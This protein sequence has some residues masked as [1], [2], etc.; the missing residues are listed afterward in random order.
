MA[1]RYLSGI[2]VDSNTLFVDSANDRVGIGTASPTFKLEVNGGLGAGVI[3][4]TSDSIEQIVVRLSSDNNKQLILGRTSTAAR[5]FGVTQNVGYVPLL[6]NE[7]GGN[8]L[9]GTTTDAGYKLDVSGTGRFT[10]VLSTNSVLLAG[11]AANIDSSLAVQVSSE[12]TGTQKWIGVNKN[13]SYGLIIGYNEISA[14]LSG[15]GAYIRQVTSDPM[16]FVVNNATTALT[17]ASTGAA[18]F[19]S[20]VTATNL[21]LTDAGGGAIN[22]VNGNLF[23]Q[24]P[25][26]TGWIFRNGASGFAE[27]M[28]LNAS[29]NLSIGNTND[30]FKLDVNGTARITGQVNSETSFYVVATPPAN[31]GGLIN[32][33]DTVTAT[34]VTSFGG[35]FFNSSPGSDY[36]IGKL[37]ENGTGFLQVRNANN[38]SEL[39]RIDASGISTFAS[40]VT[41]SSL[42]K[43]GGT[44]S[45]YL[46]AD[47]SVSTTATINNYTQTFFVPDTSGTAQWVKL[48]TWTAGQGGNVVTVQI[49]Q[50][51]GYNAT[52]SQNQQVYIYM[53]T[54]NGSSVDVNGFAGDSS[55]WT[56]G[57]NQAIQSGDVIWEANAA[58]VGATSYTLYVNMGAFT[59]ASQYTVT[60][61]GGTWSNVGTLTSPSGTTPSSTILLSENRFVVNNILTVGGAASGNVL[62]GTYTDAGYKLSVAGDILASAASGNRSVV[63]TTNNANAALNVIAGLGAELATDGTNQ[64]IAFRT[65]ATTRM[66][67]A[68]SGNVGIGITNPTVK[69]D[70]DGPGRFVSDGASRVLYLKQDANN[71]GN[72]IQFQNESGTNTWELVGRNN[73]FYFYNANLANF[74]IYI[75]PATSNVS[76]SSSTDIGDKLFVNGTIAAVGGITIRESGSGILSLVRQNSG[77]SARTYYYENANLYWDVGM[78]GGSYNWRVNDPNFG[79]NNKLVVS[80]GFD[81]G[82]GIGTDSPTRRL[83]IVGTTRHERVYAYANNL[84]QFANDIPQ[85]E[86]WLHLGTQAAFTTDKIYYRVNT[87]T[88]EEEGEIIVK[89][90]C[91]T[92][93]IEWFRNSYSVMVTAV[94]AR[95]Q[96]GCGACEIFIRVR[97][98]SNYLGAN[99]TVQWQVHNGTDS[100][101]TTVNAVATPGTGTSEANIAST[102]GYM[103]ST[104]NNQSVG[105]RLGVNT[106]SPASRVHAVEASSGISARTDLGG[107]IIAEGSTRA[108]LYI[109]TA[110]TAAGSYGSI[111][112]GNGNTNTDAYITV[113][114]DTRAMDFGT[115]DGFAM[116]ITSSRNV[117]IG[118]TTDSGYRLRVNGTSYFDGLAWFGQ[119]AGT[120][121]AFRWGALGTAVSSDTMLSMNQLWNGSGWAI[122][123]SNVGTT[124]LNLGGAVASPSIDFGTGA[125]NTEATTK[126]RITNGGNVLI[127]TTT[128]GGYKLNVNGNT[129]SNGIILG[130]DQTYGGTYRSVS[131]GANQDGA[132]RIFA[133]TDAADGMYFASATGTGFS[134]RPNGGT[135]DL[136]KITSTG[137][138]GI[139]ADSPGSKLDVDRDGRTG[140]HATSQSLYVTG[141]MGGGTTGGQA[142]N[143]EFRHSN[144]SQGIGFGYQTIYQTGDNTNEVLNILS[145]GTGALTLN[146]YAYSSGNVL[147]GTSTDNGYKLR[148]VGSTYTTGDVV[149]AKTTTV[150]ADFGGPVLSLGD[151]TSEVGM[152][153][154]IAFTEL[155]TSAVANVSMGIYYDGKANKMHFTGTSGAQATAGENLIAATKHMTITRDTGLVGIGTTNPT[156]T[157]NYG[158]ALDIQSSSGGAIYLRDSDDTTKY[159][160]LAYD[161]GATNRTSIGALGADNYLR[162]L[163][164][165]SEVIRVTASG[166][167]GIGTTSPTNK[168]H[169]NGGSIFN[170]NGFLY[171]SNQFPIVWGA[172]VSIEGDNVAGTLTLKTESS[173][174]IFINNVGNVGV[175]TTSPT[176]RLTVTTATN[177]VDVLRLNNTGGDSGS[178]QGVTHLA[179]NH[180]NSG[181]NPSTRITAYQDST[182]GWPGG[183][184]FSTRSLNTDSAPVERMRI[185]SGGNVGIGTTSPQYMLDVNGDAQINAEG[186]GPA[187]AYVPDGGFGL[188]SLITSGVENVALGKPD[189]W[190]RIHVDGVAFVFPGYQEP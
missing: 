83:H 40:S 180:F 90:T 10:G 23:L 84:F 81:W 175:G 144:G 132:N 140:S 151:S 89:N 11:G 82:V 42:I 119:S 149:V 120:G 166:N 20:S 85:N 48:G 141:T 130:T 123:D 63:L 36:S 115:A 122:L 164:A 98:G 179:I 18:T 163:S 33:R 127:G 143:I 72:I 170:Q 60:T 112:W 131:F 4:S 126:M 134:F 37:T 5:I 34:N 1:I 184:Y 171:M 148:V 44:S 118:T 62:I 182:S 160:L 66:Y 135:A 158:R 56:E 7:A 67:I 168:L 178:V 71:S 186:T 75:H 94:K 32:V 50:H 15:I 189:V 38:G 43:S 139:G 138:V 14:G 183:M 165:S 86:L 30:T 46:M 69:L 28:R 114:N 88:S 188:D 91:V 104:S 107:T 124:Y 128:D 162:I 174:R 103:V 39:L 65:G 9:I 145:R 102:D 136:V 105:G 137:N 142:G 87:N 26:G 70:V 61:R 185:T 169:V 2:N 45:E 116:R 29:G 19:S 31:N 52:T 150:N 54:S 51:A 181:T 47:G 35:I 59:N 108:G 12:G 80:Q 95:M 25:A 161:G 96:G 68:S 58:G 97:Y 133:T 109:L 53:K 146:A 106:T 121:S 110:G 6:L 27:Y 176:N 55:F 74:P 22:N 92:A 100:G 57:L 153:G 101:F 173:H 125:Q 177:A 156:D 21:N 24:T 152:A 79:V 159:G 190:L 73:Q 147:I 117:L 111:W 172:A 41:A 17:L 8:V 129:Q 167:V 64:N 154:G 3:T 157:L 16:Y 155:L 76:M 187:Y 77:F 93:N 113:G 99:T 78:I 49:D 13:G